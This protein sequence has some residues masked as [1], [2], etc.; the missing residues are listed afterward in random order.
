MS[1]DRQFGAK[2]IIEIDGTPLRD[3]IADALLEEVVIDDH[4]HMPDML[5]FR[6]RDE[7]HDVL[8]RAGIRIGSKVTV[9]A[10]PVGD[11]EQEPLI[12]AEVTAIEGQ[13]GTT[14]SVA[15]VRG[16][17]LSHR[18]CRGRKT[19]TFLNAAD[20]DLANQL[21][22]DAGVEVGRVDTTPGIHDHISQWNQTDWEFLKAR[23]Q[24]IGYEVAVV[25]GKLEY[26][27]PSGPASAPSAG[28]LG[29]GASDP[30]QLVLGAN[31]MW[32]RPRV[33]AAEQVNEVV[34]RSW[35]RANKQP[36]MATANVATTSAEVGITPTQ[37]IDA[38][39]GSPRYLSPD[40]AIDSTG[41]AESAAKA[42]MDQIAGAHYEADGEALGNP[43]L[44][45]GASVSIGQVGTAFDGKVMIT[46]TRHIYG[47]GGY[48]TAF[49]VSGRQER[50]LL[51]V[52]SMGRTKGAQ[53]GGGAPVP[54]VVIGL[55]T[56]NSDPDDLGRVKVKF[57]WLS[58]DFE[59][60]W[61]PVTQ[62]GAGSERGMFFLPEVNDEVLVAFN[63]GD[64]RQPVII[65]QL[66]NGVDKP[67]DARD[68]IDGTSG[69]VKKR[70]ITS[71][72]GNSIEFH[73]DSSKKGIDVTTAGGGYKITLDETNT[74][75]LVSSD[76]TIE[77][78]GAGDITIKSSSGSLT[79]E[80]AQAL[81]L[82]AATGVKIDGGT[83]AEVKAAA[84]L[85]LDG[86]A[87]VQ[88][89][90]ASVQLG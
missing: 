15:V 70:S 12:V 36:I 88:V 35:D 11:G 85:T 39:G 2:P 68:H 63:H 80:A 5:T 4:L 29:S 41:Q 40:R 25:L 45:A 43:K 51:G 57:P 8:D 90:G 9:S 18:L 19:R 66:Y 60:W 71:K 79:L 55:V 78:Q 46:S 34:V 44:R 69:G 72:L 54:G 14:G 65:G 32:F 16:Y 73:D 50:S 33:T 48:R 7:A 49:T 47:A 13:F 20:A 84:G 27:N 26:R 6:L 86:G 89:K 31:L 76:G 64:I 82:K 77:I 17:D 23:A 61:A 53:S 21:A 10:T 52:V 81:E 67:K 28:D 59:T 56:D 58:D 74:S 38:F 1:G 62:L 42:L 37:L 87:M 22:S 75:I 24:E 3:D 30:L 83:Q